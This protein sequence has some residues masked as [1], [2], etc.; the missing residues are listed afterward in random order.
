MIF[1]A[2]TSFGK[3]YTCIISTEQVASMSEI[4]KVK[5]VT[6]PLWQLTAFRDDP[7]IL[8]R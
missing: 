2:H 6:S 3:S 5:I 4:R 8:W 1:T 7:F